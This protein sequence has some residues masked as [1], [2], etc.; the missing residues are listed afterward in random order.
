MDFRTYPVKRYEQRFS[1]Q[2]YE[3]V[4]T[5][6]NKARLTRLNEL[7]DLVN[8]SFIDDSRFTESDF[9]KVVNEVHNLIYARGANYFYPEVTGHP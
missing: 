5:P 1:P 2:K 9:K 6:H 8:D 7:S 3:D 4:I